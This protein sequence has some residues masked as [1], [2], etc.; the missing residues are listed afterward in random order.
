MA[1][2]EA[3]EEKAAIDRSRRP[4]RRPFRPLRLALVL[5]PFAAFFG[6]AASS[7]SAGASTARPE[8][9][10]TPASPAAPPPAS[11]SASAGLGSGS[12][13]LQAV[14]CSRWSA[15][16]ANS[17]PSKPRD[18]TD[19]RYH[20]WGPL[21][22]QR[23]EPLAVQQLAE[24]LPLDGVS[25]ELSG[26]E[27][28]N[29]LAAPTTSDGRPVYAPEATSAAG[30]ATGDS[31][32]G[33][34][35]VA[36]TSLSDPQRAALV[37]GTG[38]WVQA[39]GYPGEF[40]NLRCHEDR[41]NA[42][43]L[44]VI[45]VA[46]GDGPLVA[47][48]VLYVIAAP[49]VPHVVMPTPGPAPVVTAPSLDTSPSPSVSPSPPLPAAPA[50][51]VPAPVDGPAVP[52]APA[53]PVSPPSG[54]AAPEQTEQPELVPSP[55]GALPTDGGARPMPGADNAVADGSLSV[56][57]LPEPAAAVATTTTVVDLMADLPA[58]PEPVAAPSPAEGQ[59]APPVRATTVMISPYFVEEPME[60]A[61]DEQAAAGLSGNGS[62]LD[63]GAVAALSALFLTG[64]GLS[65]L[66]ARRPL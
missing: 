62:R 40:A 35:D 54:G 2:T 52:V 12:V 66:A 63:A 51:G 39:T 37:D 18:D 42:D 23:V 50:V 3:N 57:R 5:L 46:A 30:G 31:G 38:L 59:T 21:D 4:G 45:R 58:P 64:L 8:T 55:A 22:P 53:P 13:V 27:Y 20:D 25:F 10:T 60:Q 16:P 44:E 49:V 32:A 29:G 36:L 19:G 56:E 1:A 48:C 17:T 28:G 41:Y 11:G 34:L 47:A 26:T 61:G 43:N 6:A 7:A 14:S 9:D 33:T 15:V 24:C 65:V